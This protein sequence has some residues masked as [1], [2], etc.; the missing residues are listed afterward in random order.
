MMVMVHSLGVLCCGSLRNGG[1]GRNDYCCCFSW[2]WLYESG[3]MI[4]VG[5]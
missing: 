1:K 5:E 2:L 3:W 4:G